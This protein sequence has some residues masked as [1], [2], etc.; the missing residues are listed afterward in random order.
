MSECT[1][2][3]CSICDAVRVSEIGPDAY[4]DLRNATPQELLEAVKWSL[5][6]SDNEPWQIQRALT[7][8]RAGFALAQPGGWERVAPH[9][10]RE[11]RKV[12]ALGAK[13]E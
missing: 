12:A 8:L 2:E 13:G 5:C 1:I 10:L 7:F 6:Q 3:R 9:W 4:D 11:S